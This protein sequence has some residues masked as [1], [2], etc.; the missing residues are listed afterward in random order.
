MYSHDSEQLKDYAQ[1]FNQWWRYCN[2][3]HIKVYND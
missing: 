3:Y 1:Y 2:N